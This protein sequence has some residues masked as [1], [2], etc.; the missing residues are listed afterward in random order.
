M[1]DALLVG[2]KWNTRPC[3]Q[4]MAFCPNLFW[5]LIIQY[6]LCAWGSRG[7]QGFNCYS[8]SKTLSRWLCL[9]VKYQSHCSHCTGMCRFNN[10]HCTVCIRGYKMY[11][12]CPLYIYV[13]AFAEIVLNRLGPGYRPS[14]LTRLIGRWRGRW[15][16]VW[17]HAAT[18]PPRVM[19]APSWCGLGCCSLLDSRSSVEHINKGFCFTPWIMRLSFLF[20]SVLF[21]AFS[22]WMSFM[23][24]PNLRIT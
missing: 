24:S 18:L 17:E 21:Y 22:L 19:A 2:D 13:H 12:A 20:F 11:Q 9:F 5:R 14:A 1:H 7:F 4:G 23:Q 15:L 10:R 3:G 16:G 6:L 8:F